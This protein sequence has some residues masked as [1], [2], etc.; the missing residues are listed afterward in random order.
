MQ[1]YLHKFDVRNIYTWICEV[2]QSE[3]DLISISVQ[4]FWNKQAE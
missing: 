1:L 4:I 2:L 3:S